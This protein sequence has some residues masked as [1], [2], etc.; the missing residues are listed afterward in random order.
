MT[1]LGFHFV[2]ILP[3]IG[4]LLWL[5]RKSGPI[6]YPAPW[7]ATVCLCGIAFVYTTPWDNYLVSR[8]IWTYDEGRVLEDLRLG[9]V[10]IEEYLFFLLQPILT[11]LFLF[12]FAQRTP[13]VIRMAKKDRSR[14]SAL[15]W[16]AGV[17]FLLL[18]LISLATFLSPWKSGTYL[19][20]ILVWSAPILSFQSFFGF[21]RIL[22]FWKQWVPAF[23][24]STSYL[25]L[26]D[27]LAIDWDIWR[28]TESTSTGLMI[29]ALPIEEGVFFAVTNLMVLFGIVLFQ[30]VLI[31]WKPSE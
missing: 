12:L 5:V 26:V 27:G 13:E 9:A 11:G 23:V 18:A 17:A 1:Y 16:I 21:D 3:I 2:F 31:R 29:F 15:R 20:L 14:R 10:P 4:V 19:S 25:W 22:R 8:E 24:G 7:L 6:P 28:I 30:D